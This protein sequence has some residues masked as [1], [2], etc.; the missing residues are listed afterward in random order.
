VG[1][2]YCGPRRGRHVR[3]CRSPTI[4]SRR[5]ARDSRIAPLVR[6]TSTY[7]VPG[8]VLRVAVDPAAQIRRRRPK[9]TSMCFSTTA[10]SFRLEPGRPP[11]RGRAARDV[12]RF[13]RAR[14]AAGWGLGPETISKAGRAA[15]EA[16]VGKG[17]VFGVRSG[18]HV[19]RGQP[20][21]HV[22]VP[23]QRESISS[24]RSVRPGDG[25]FW[26]L[27]YPLVH[28]YRQEPVPAGRRSMMRSF[29]LVL[30]GTLRPGGRCFSRRIS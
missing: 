6:R 3:V 29:V 21:R 4:S 15:F 18:D 14:C 24:K 13:R 26:R 7:Y 27:A 10:P 9:N 1:C 28:G 30:W 11:A 17:K 22:Q 8:S 5:A 2:R 12:V 19:F 20:P 23:V 16:S 25:G